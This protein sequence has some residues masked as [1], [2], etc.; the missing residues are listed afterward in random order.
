MSDHS[1]AIAPSK[2]KRTTRTRT[3]CYTCRVRRIKCD[4]TKPICKRCSI[5]DKYCDGYMYQDS[6]KRDFVLHASRPNVNEPAPTGWLVLEG[7]EWRKLN[8]RPFGF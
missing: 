7:C 4:E 3:G 2:T 8:W 6:I 1:T 5:A